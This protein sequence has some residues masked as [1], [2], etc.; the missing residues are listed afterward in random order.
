MS[1]S[2]A[3]LADEILGGALTDPAKNPHDPT[4]GHQAEMPAMDPN[5]T[6]VEMSDTQRALLMEAAGVEATSPEEPPEEV[7]PLG[8]E[9]PT[10]TMELTPGELETLAEA[11]RI[12]TKIQEATTVGSIG[13]N[14][15]GGAKGDAKSI[16]L[17]GDVNSSSQPKK[18]VK[19]KTKTKEHDFLSYL[20]A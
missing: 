11:K 8:R 17:P 3:Q 20:K 16:K 14:M 13:V 10:I 6:L 9:T 1:K 2:Y 4:T 18:R 15:A 12:I 19:K 7:T 5:D